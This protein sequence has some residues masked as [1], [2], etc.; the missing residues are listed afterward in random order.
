M[1]LLR[2]PLNF[3]LGFILLILIVALSI[4]FKAKSFVEND[5]LIPTFKE[6]L[7]QGISQSDLNEDETKLV[8][9]IIKD[10]DFD[11]ILKRAVVNFKEYFTNKDY[12]LSKDD[13]ELA[14]NYVLRYREELNALEETDYSEEKIRELLNYN[15]ANDMVKELFDG[16]YEG[17]DRESFSKVITMY[18]MVISTGIKTILFLAIVVVLVL[19]TLVNWSFYKWLV[20]TGVDL[21]IS[22]LLFSGIFALCHEARIKLIETNSDITGVVN[23]ININSFILIAF[24]EIAA[25]I[26]MIIGYQRTKNIANVKVTKTHLS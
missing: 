10:N 1:K 18:E 26:L 8:T 4:S 11:K 16:I 19:I 20:I 24:I 2:G 7:V 15:D 14:L 21:I 3:I 22:G 9:K 5:F 12:S 6:M 13:Y 23:S 25:G 17:A